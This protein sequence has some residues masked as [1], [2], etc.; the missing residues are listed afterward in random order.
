MYTYSY[1]IYTT[2]CG[3]CIY[4]YKDVLIVIPYDRKSHKCF[5]RSGLYG[6]SGHIYIYI[7]IYI[8]I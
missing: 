7:Y 2:I 3:N 1:Y 4:E 5:N 8:Y 6:K